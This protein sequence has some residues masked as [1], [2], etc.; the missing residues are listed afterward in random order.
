MPVGWDMGPLDFVNQ[1]INWLL[2]ALGVSLIASGL[3]KLC[4][5]A[6]LRQRSYLRLVLWGF[7]AGC[8]A[9]VISV[10]LFQGDGRMQG[11]YLLIAAVASGIGWAAWRRQG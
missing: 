4:W 11:Y 7:V 2:P 1:L 5:Y 6:S 8:L 10:I 9:Q 3:V